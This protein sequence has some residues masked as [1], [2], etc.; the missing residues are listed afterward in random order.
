MII[1]QI[2][3]GPVKMIMSVQFHWGLVCT[4]LHAGWR[5]DRVRCVIMLACWQVESDALYKFRWV[6]QALPCAPCN[7]RKVS[8]E[9][10]NYI[11]RCKNLVIIKLQLTSFKSCSDYAMGW[12]S[13]GAIPGR[14][15]RFDS[16]LKFPDEHW[17]PSS[18][19]LVAPPQ[20]WSGEN[21]KMTTQ[22][23]SSVKRPSAPP[24]CALI[25]CTHHI[26]PLLLQYFKMCR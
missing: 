13:Q 9:C 26:Y 11:T 21:T 3:R 1:T 15:K 4:L 2:G 7:R 17:G 25:A 14:D 18:G 20:Q 19:G 16:P 22:P 23:P 5:T 24:L 12:T 8:V 10:S 6:L